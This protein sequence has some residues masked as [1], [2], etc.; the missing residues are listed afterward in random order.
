MFVH[1][2]CRS[3]GRPLLLG[4]GVGRR[5]EPPTIGWWR[6]ADL[7]HGQEPC[8][9]VVYPRECI[10][11][12]FDH[13]AAVFAKL[14]QPTEEQVAKWEQRLREL[15]KQLAEFD[16]EPPKL[17][18]SAV[19]YA[20]WGW[21]VFPL[22]E[23]TKR[24]ATR[25]GFH[26]ATTDVVRIRSYWKGRPMANIGIATG[27]RFDVLDID[28]PKEKDGK[29]TPDGRET[30]TK[31]LEQVDPKDGTGA[32]PDCYG[33]NATPTGG[34]HLLIL[35]TGGGNRGGLLPGID[36][37]GLG[38]YVVAPPSQRPQGRY[39]WEVAPAPQVRRHA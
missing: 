26:D 37:R 19:L 20:Q 29:M 25:N 2:T 14:R 23:D 13:L 8:R 28:V 32:L 35:P 15:E 12:E 39:R 1:S 18:E 34:L 5:G 22:I 30:L 27:H 21:P 36:T 16:A 10:Q 7:W 3:C 4:S 33:I 31:L 6:G 38:G 9:P 17:L 24:P 11:D